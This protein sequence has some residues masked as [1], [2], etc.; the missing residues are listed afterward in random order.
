MLQ[1]IKVHAVTTF[2]DLEINF[3]TGLN[4]ITGENGSG[5][6]HLLKIAYSIIAAAYHPERREAP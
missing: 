3:S 6:S 4:V 2:K 1:Q 5:K